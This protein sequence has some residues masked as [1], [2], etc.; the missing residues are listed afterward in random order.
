MLFDRA[1]LVRIASQSRLLCL[2]RFEFDSGPP[3]PPVESPIPQNNYIA[4]DR[5]ALPDRG[6]IGREIPAGGP[7]AALGDARNMLF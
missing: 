6:K 1:G 4:E 3:L 7:N 5:R 2:E